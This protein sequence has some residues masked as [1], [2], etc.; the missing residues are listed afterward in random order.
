MISVF[1][2]VTP[3]GPVRLDQRFCGTYRFCL[4]ETTKKQAR[5][6]ACF[7]LGLLFYPEGGG[8]IFLRNVD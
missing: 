5:I 8:N 6:A 7:S 4:Q 2:D 1:G 3:C